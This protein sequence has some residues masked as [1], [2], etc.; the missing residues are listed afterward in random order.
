MNRTPSRLSRTN[1][2]TLI[3]LLVVIAIIAILAAILFPVFARA[4]ENARRASCQ[5]NLKQIG[6]GT[7]QYV[8]DHDERLPYQPN[9]VSIEPFTNPPSPAQSN[10]FYKIQPYVKSW[11][12]FRCP[13]ARLST[14]SDSPIGENDT[15]YMVNGVIS[16]DP[17]GLTGRH[18][19]SIPEVATVIAIQEYA[20]RT[21]NVYLRPQ[22]ATATTLQYWLPNTSYSGLHF[23]GGNLLFADG[24]VK[25]RKQSSICA[26]E[27]GLGTPSGGPACGAP[28]T[29]T[30]LATAPYLY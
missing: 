19:A 12:L 13:S 7:M 28:A 14:T 10:Y 22:R 30:N 2:F 3:E 8:Q 24:H 16:T 29:G 17:N 26:S 20:F 23:D 1:A 9:A 25:F 21:R 27:Y 4:R 6:L 11:Q 5:S 18:I 15:N